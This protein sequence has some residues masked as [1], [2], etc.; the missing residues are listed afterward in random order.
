MLLKDNRHLRE[1]ASCPLRSYFIRE[2]DEKI[3]KIIFNLF[4]A[5][6]YVFPEEWDNPKY[7]I[8]AK[9]TGYGAVMKAFPDL[10]ELGIQQRKLSQEF[11]MDA[12]QFFK[13]ELIKRDVKLSSAYFASGEQEQRRLA[14][15]I[16]ESASNSNKLV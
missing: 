10:F 5:I 9:T 15:I 14:N 13:M 1:D 16:V 7:S 3:Y 11:F 6:R 2:Q 12:F 4:S 8:L